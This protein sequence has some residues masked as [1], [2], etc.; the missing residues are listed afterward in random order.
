MTEYTPKVGDRVRAT[1][2]IEGEVTADRGDGY[3]FIE[4]MSEK[5]RSELFYKHGWSFEKLQDPE[6]KW[7]NGDVV[8][9]NGDVMSRVEGKW[10][11]VEHGTWDYELAEFPWKRGWVEILYKADAEK[12][13]A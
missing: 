10:V 8:S 2:V 4:V 13:A 1:R 7:V 11:Y 9:I 5:G 3:A 6:P 12:E